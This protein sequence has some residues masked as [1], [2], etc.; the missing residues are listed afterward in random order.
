MERATNS[1]DASSWGEED[2]LA[3]PDAAHP[4]HEE[5]QAGSLP[6]QAIPG[7]RAGFPLPPMF[8]LPPGSSNSSCL[9]GAIRTEW[10]NSDKALKTA[11]Q[12]TSA[13]IRKEYRPSVPDEEMEASSQLL[14]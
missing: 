14:Q 4:A 5:H 13:T 9:L 2:A 10:L 11:A 6:G 12:N 8:L 3:V 1:N 7:S